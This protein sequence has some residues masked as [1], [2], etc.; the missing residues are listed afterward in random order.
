MK[1]QLSKIAALFLIAGCFAIP[2]SAQ[3]KKPADAVAVK[4]APPSTSPAVED[5][6]PEPST[7]DLPAGA[8]RASE[9]FVR[10]FI[11]LEKAYNHLQSRVPNGYVYD[12]VLQA[13]IPATPQPAAVHPTPNAPVPGAAPAPGTPPAKP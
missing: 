1:T 3:E 6:I 5:P 7:K 13:F 10:E 2:C 4:A 9:S 12:K 11:A 8:L